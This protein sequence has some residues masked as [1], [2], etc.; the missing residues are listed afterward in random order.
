MREYHTKLIIVLHFKVIQGLDLIVALMDVKEISQ[1]EVGPRFAYGAF[2]NGK[3]IPADATILYT[4]E[5]KKVDKEKEL[6]NVNIDE[7]LIIG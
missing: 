1:I 4:V 6:D 7:R 2:G 5:L 3:D